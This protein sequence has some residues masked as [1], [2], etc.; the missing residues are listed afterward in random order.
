MSDGLDR[1]EFL[2]RSAAAGLALAA[3]PAAAADAAPRVRRRVTLGRTGLRVG[4]IGFGSSEL[5]EEEHLV[6]HALDR[7]IDYFDTAD[8]YTGGVAETTIGKALRGKRDQVT[9]VTKAKLA[10]TDRKEDMMAKLERSLRRLQTDHVDVY[11]NHAVNEVARV[12]NPEWPEF[13]AL[14]R[15][16]GKIRFVGMSGHGGM[17]IECID[18]VVQNELVDVLLVSFNFG[19]D[20]AF[21]ERILKRLDLIAL[22]PKLPAALARAKA[23]GI[24]VV[25][26]K[27]LHGAR[28]N[29]LTPFQKDGPTFA[30]AAFRWVLSHPSVDSL[31]V[32]MK[33]P[34]QIDEYLGAS[35]WTRTA[36]SD[37]RVLARHEARERRRQCRYGCSACSGACP[38]GVE[39]SEV[40]RTRMYAED[41]G[42]PE[43]ARSEYA[44]I[45]TNAAACLSCS[46]QPCAT[47]CPHGL[48]VSELTGRTAR[49]LS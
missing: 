11:F 24:G 23:K 46:G 38:A 6:R 28:H 3:G 41:Y 7:G 39:I 9:L 44:Q 31:I 48:P 43:L 15:K 4:D 45:G 8:G 49:L 42:S 27:T 29:D 22:Q 21:Y 14:A 19:Q 5:R 10:A 35:G 36:A 17:L 20:P 18:H 37:G 34:A 16:Q 40:L 12:S 32:T 26:M 13:N 33:S 1:R 47:A 25:A 2:Q 30:Q